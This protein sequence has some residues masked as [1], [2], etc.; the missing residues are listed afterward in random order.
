[1]EARA[2]LQ[3]SA[4]NLRNLSVF[5]ATLPSS[6]DAA[7]AWSTAKQ[8]SIDA[9]VRSCVSRVVLSFCHTK[10]VTHTSTSSRRALQER[11]EIEFTC[12]SVL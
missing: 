2:A 11:L 8:Y 10:N 5:C 12:K 7:T 4:T 9:L 6:G 1:M 3:A